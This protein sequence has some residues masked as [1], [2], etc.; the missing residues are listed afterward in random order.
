[1]SRTGKYRIL[2]TPS[3]AETRVKGSRFI[4]ICRPAT[5]LAEASATRD[6][7]RRRFHDATHHVYA[8]RL[9]SGEERFDD[10]GEPSG[11]AGRPVLSSIRRAGLV[12]AVVVVTRYFGGTKLGTGG[13]GRAYAAAADLALEAAGVRSVAAARRVIVSFDYGDTGTVTRCAEA[14]GAVRLGDHYGERAGI[15]LAIRANRVP[16]FR[17]DVAELTGGRGQVLELDGEMWLPVDT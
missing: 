2:A 12:D 7:E 17:E 6:E 3:E 10:D 5:D 11:T 14:A 4:A 13:L 8:S 1:M 15:E 9:R 16:R